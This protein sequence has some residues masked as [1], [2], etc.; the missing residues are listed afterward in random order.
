M[1]RVLVAVAVAVSLVFAVAAFGADGTAPAK[2]AG[3]SFEE[4][5]AFHLKKLDERIKSLQDERVC[6]EAAQ[7][8]DALKACWQKHRAE[9]K[10]H[11]GPMKGKGGPGWQGDQGQPPAK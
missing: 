11:R 9:M 8:P 1:K 10:E 2:A 7:T 4:K 3:M 5:K 6:A